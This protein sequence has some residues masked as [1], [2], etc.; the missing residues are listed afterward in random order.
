MEVAWIEEFR[1]NVDA[2]RA[3][4]VE[5]AQ[6][7]PDIAVPARFPPTPLPVGLRNFSSLEV[8]GGPD[9]RFTR[10][11]SMYGRA[12]HN[13]RPN[14]D[15]GSMG[16][17][18]Q[19][20]H[21]NFGVVGD[22]PRE[23]AYDFRTYSAEGTLL[24]G[25]YNASF[26]CRAP[27]LSRA[28]RN[29]LQHATNGNVAHVR[30]TCY[31]SRRDRNRLQHALNGN[32]SDPSAPMLPDS[33]TVDASRCLA[34]VFKDQRQCGRRPFGSSPYCRQHARSLPHGTIVGEMEPAVQAKFARVQRKTFGQRVK[35][36]YS[37][38]KLWDEARLM[39]KCPEELTDEEFD[40][41]FVEYPPLFCN[42]PCSNSQL[43]V[44]RKQGPAKRSRSTRSGTS[45]LLGPPAPFHVLL[46]QIFLYRSW[47]QFV[48]ALR[49]RM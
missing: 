16:R 38:L 35:T 5:F 14:L 7:L 2:R 12:K 40:S 20:E 25:L 44:A 49:S 23:E 9:R 19:L 42:E 11:H 27:Y 43:A 3:A 45:E 46:R 29:R 36:W 33:V 32:M 17:L 21:T 30:G 47:K 34:R 41:C 24:Q 28:A 15:N 48:Q 39:G 37:R 13:S 10:T 31:I 8:A 1:R 26:R 22:L 6:S 4:A 18:E